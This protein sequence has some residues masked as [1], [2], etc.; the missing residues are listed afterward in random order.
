M[1]SRCRLG[2]VQQRP[3]QREGRGEQ[4]EDQLA[5]PHPV[6]R[7]VD[8]VAR[9]RRVQPARHVIAA[10]LDDQALDVEEQVL[11]GAVVGDLPDRVLR[12]A[13]QGIAQGA[14]FAGGDD[15][16]RRE[17]HEVRVVDR[18]HRREQLSLGILEIFVE[19]AGHIFR[20]KLHHSQY[21]AI[22][23][24]HMKESP[25]S[26]TATTHRR[27]FLARLVGTAAALRVTG[28]R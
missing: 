19:N 20:R 23:F 8:V 18:H 2:E 22:P 14:G 11:V 7:H 13:V 10:G 4:A 24:L 1:V 9:A 21:I 6:H 26:L 12:H 3:A 16:L 17:H 15:P 28:G 27:G 25:M 5:L